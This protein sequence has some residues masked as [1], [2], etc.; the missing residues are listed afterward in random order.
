MAATTFSDVLNCGVCNERY[1]NPRVLPCQHVFCETCLIKLAEGSSQICCPDCQQAYPLSESGVKDLKP[2]F[3]IGSI[4]ECVDKATGKIKVESCNDRGKSKQHGGHEVTTLAV[5]STPA[6]YCSTNAGN[7]LEFYSDNY[8]EAVRKECLQSEHSQE[9]HKHRSLSDVVSRNNETLVWYVEQLLIK[10]SEI[11]HNKDEIQ[12]SWK[13]RCQRYQQE[14]TGLYKRTLEA[15]K[16]I[17]SVEGKQL[18]AQYERDEEHEKRVLEMMQSEEAVVDSTLA[19]IMNMLH[20]TSLVQSVAAYP[21][22]LQCLERMVN[23][24][25]QCYQS[26][27]INDKQSNPK[28]P[29]EGLQGVATA[30]DN[31]QSEKDSSVDKSA[32]ITYTTAMRPVSI[33]EQVRAGEHIRIGLLSVEGKEVYGITAELQTPNGQTKKLSV[34]YTNDISENITHEVNFNSNGIGVNKISLAIQNVPLEGSPYKINVLPPWMLVKTIGRFGNDS[35]PDE[36][37]SV[38][39]ITVNKH[40]EI[41]AADTHSKSLLVIDL[42]SGNVLRMIHCPK[43]AE[44]FDPC[45]I[46]VTDKC[47]CLFN[48]SSNQ[49]IACD[50]YGKPIQCFGEDVLQKPCVHWFIQLHRPLPIC[51]ANGYC[52]NTHG[53]VIV[54]VKQSI[55]AGKSSSLLVYTSKGELLHP[56][57]TDVVDE[58]D[59]AYGRIATDK[60]NNVYLCDYM[61]N[62]IKK[63]DSKCRFIC[64]LDSARD[65]LVGVVGLAVINETP[66]RV[67][68]LD[69]GH[70]P[71]SILL[72][73]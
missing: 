52:V 67:V 36:Y 37:A 35:D 28:Q 26:L 46:A 47:I 43:F 34:T 20:H 15:T 25:T 68:T 33:P 12:K 1:R 7:I 11:K 54:S 63:Y 24:E 53:H 50:N 56:C 18:A 10:Q 23:V 19:A 41:I 38:S 45:D 30:T 16:D 31:N 69:P 14:L 4:L 22:T 64:N 13:E 27:P 9:E 6:Q 48:Y 70:Y 62:K 55:F 5:R 72:F 44:S 49:I 61:E 21:E 8:S 39:C 66:C 3:F 51:R 60:D 59:T 17:Q 71:S 73:A 42:Q 2:G 57:S 65:G 32:E 40:G 29:M 58:D